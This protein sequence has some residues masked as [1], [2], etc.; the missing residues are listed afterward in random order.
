MLRSVCPLVV[1]VAGVM[2]CL[3]CLLRGS[4]RR[5]LNFHPIFHTSDTAPENQNGDN[6]GQVRVSPRGFHGL[7]VWVVVIFCNQW[8]KIRRSHV[9]HG[10]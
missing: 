9:F 8:V 5:S 3:F 1:V 6:R 10:E 2:V 4:E 7:D